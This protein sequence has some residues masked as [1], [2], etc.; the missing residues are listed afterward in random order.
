MYYNKTGYYVRKCKKKYIILIILSSYLFFR[1][2]G[3]SNCNPQL[4]CLLPEN[5]E[6]PLIVSVFLT[7]RAASRENVHLEKKILTSSCFSAVLQFVSEALACTVL[8]SSEWLSAPLLPLHDSHKHTK[9]YA[10]GK[11]IK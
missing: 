5:K 9:D 3:S 11:K 10:R 6:N 2:C 1:V 4:K 8:S 7:P